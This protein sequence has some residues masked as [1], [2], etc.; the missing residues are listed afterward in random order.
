LHRCPSCPLSATERASRS[1]LSGANSTDCPD[2]VWAIAGCKRPS[3]PPFAL[4]WSHNVDGVD[5]DAIVPKVRQEFAAKKRRGKSQSQSRN[6]RR[7]RIERN[8]EMQISEGLFGSAHFLL[9]VFPPSRSLSLLRERHVLLTHCEREPFA[10]AS[11]VSQQCLESSV[12]PVERTRW[13]EYTPQRW[14]SRICNCGAHRTARPCYPFRVAASAFAR[15]NS[16]VARVNA[17]LLRS[18]TDSILSLF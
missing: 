2:S 8:R 7:R 14:P 4:S 5:T 10:A 16:V 6:Q 12:R 3:E 11:S 13:R 9:P 1:R 18:L 15:C 17:H